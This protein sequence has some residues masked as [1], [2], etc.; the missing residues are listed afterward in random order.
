MKD[1]GTDVGNATID[2]FCNEQGITTTNFASGDA[3]PR[4]SIEGPHKDFG[5][6]VRA[7]L[8]SSHLPRYLWHHV[9]AHATRQF[10]LTPSKNNPKISKHEAFYTAK[11]TFA[12][13]HDFAC[14]VVIKVLPVPAKFAPRALCGSWF[15]L[16]GETG[17]SVH[18]VA[19]AHQ[20]KTGILRRR[21]VRS[22]NIRFLTNAVPAKDVFPDAMFTDGPLS[23]DDPALA[24][25]YDGQGRL[26][27]AGQHD[28]TCATCKGYGNGTVIMCDYCPAS[29]CHLCSMATTE[30]LACTEWRCPLCRASDE[31][32]PVQLVHEVDDVPLPP[33]GDGA[34]V[35][36]HRRTSRMS[37]NHCTPAT[38]LNP[39]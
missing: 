15:G 19:V 37:T 22:R 36:R 1:E 24:P 18:L 34:S 32:I 9:V 31:A 11:P 21:I 27:Y 17:H 28:D 10:N 13:L 2:T 3:R 35:P 29:F 26:L 38:V 23:E 30:Q 39:T 16:A 12:S 7:L 25:R 5:R 20:T 33:L 8:E 14:P 6:K 4:G